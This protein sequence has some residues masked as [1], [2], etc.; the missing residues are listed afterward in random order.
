[1]DSSGPESES[2]V[3]L[4]SPSTEHVPS[5]PRQPGESKPQPDSEVK[6][7]EESELQPRLAESLI[8]P[9]ESDTSQVEDDVAI[10]DGDGHRRVK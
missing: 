6:L 10:D 2:D 4:P 5:P 9:A 1:M 7:E 3:E 8:G